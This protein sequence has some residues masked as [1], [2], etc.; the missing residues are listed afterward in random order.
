IKGTMDASARALF[1]SIQRFKT[2]PDYLQL[3]PGHGAGSACGKALGAVPSTTLG[4]ERIANWAL[5]IDNEDEFVRSVLAGQPE[6]PKYFAQMK[7]INK[8]GPRS[9]GSLALPPRAPSD[10]L[11]TVLEKGALVVDTRKAAAYATAH[12]PGTINIPLNK[13]FTNWAGAL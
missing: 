1:A 3:W 13:S 4:Y 12:I 7:R 9:I 8:E 5:A 11:A 10:S 6:P 2:L